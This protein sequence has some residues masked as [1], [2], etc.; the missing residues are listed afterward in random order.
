VANKAAKKEAKVARM[1]ESKAKRVESPN[2]EVKM[3]KFREARRAKLAEINGVCANP[4]CGVALY[5]NSKNGRCFDCR[6]CPGARNSGCPKRN[7]AHQSNK[8]FRGMCASC[9]TIQTK[10]E[11]KEEAELAAQMAAAILEKK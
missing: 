2:R 5:K 4:D 9:N 7:K 11:E 10:M 8:K 3:A 1:A 6:L